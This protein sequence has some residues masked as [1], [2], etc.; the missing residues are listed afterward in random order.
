[1]PEAERYI[2][3]QRIF[4]MHVGRSGDGK[5]VAAASYLDAPG[6][7]TVIDLDFDYRFGGIKSAIDQKIIEGK[8]IEFEQFNPRKGWDPVDKWL[9][10]AEIYQ[11]DYMRTGKFRYKA[12]ICDSLTSLTRLLVV[13]SHALQGGRKLGQLRIS[14]PGDFNFE[15][16][17]THQFFDF[18]RTFPCHV[19]CSAHLIDK[20]G[21]LKPNEEYSEKG[22]VGE[23][24]SVRDN[25]GENVLTYFDN[26]FRFSREVKGNKTFYYVEF[27]TDLAKNS[28]GIPPGLHDITGKR[29]YP[30]LQELIKKHKVV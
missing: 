19:I 8:G 21:K 13:G 16:N 7:G 28:F 6:D 23:K 10:Q 18:L 26:V 9:T 17:G 2:G 29:F 20:Y 27:A 12:V 1:M 3:D 5:S 25:L 30:Y 4:A 14:G 24:L 11:T 15:A 22:V